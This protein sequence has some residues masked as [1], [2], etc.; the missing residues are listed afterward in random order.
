MSSRHDSNRLDKS[1]RRDI[2][3][4]TAVDLWL[5]A[6]VVASIARRGGGVIP[7]G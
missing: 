4:L 1:W 6:A 5:K 2:S 7:I 3:S